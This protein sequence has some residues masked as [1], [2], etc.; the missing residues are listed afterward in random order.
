M[1]KT[2]KIKGGNT[3]SGNLIL[4]KGRADKK[5][6]SFGRDRTAEEISKRSKE[7]KSADAQRGTNLIL[8]ESELRFTAAEKD[9][10]L[11]AERIEIQNL[12]CRKRAVSGEEGSESP[13]F[14]EG[15]LR[16]AQ[17]NNSAVHAVERTLITIDVKLAGAHGD[18]AD[19][20][21][22]FTSIAMRGL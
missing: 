1:V 17:Q 12:L 9:F 4:K 16:K 6:R 3:F 20:S 21:V 8:V 10:N 2:R 22:R 7:P 19:I 11:P 14:L 5:G 15:V 13:H 18:K